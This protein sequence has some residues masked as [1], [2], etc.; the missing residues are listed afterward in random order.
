MCDR[1]YLDIMHVDCVNLIMGYISIQWSDLK[2][3]NTVATVRISRSFL[4]YAMNELMHVMQRQVDVGNARTNWCMQCN[5][6]FWG[7]WIGHSSDSPWIKND[8]GKIGCLQIYNK[9]YILEIMTVLRGHLFSLI[10]G[11]TLKIV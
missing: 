7:T 5:H 6:D 1:F 2:T 8:G 10:R 3:R 4:W 9:N 11:N